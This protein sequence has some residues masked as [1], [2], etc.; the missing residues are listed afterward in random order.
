MVIR[1]PAAK[2]RVNFGEILSRVADKG[3]EVI[4]ERLGQPI[5]RI[6]PYGKKTPELEEIRQRIAKYITG[7]DSVADIRRER[8]SH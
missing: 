6:T 4:I 5:A 7:G 3:E 8:E 1:Y 2:A